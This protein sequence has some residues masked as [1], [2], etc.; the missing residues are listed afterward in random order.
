MLHTGLVETSDQAARATAY[1]N[2]VRGALAN[3]AIVGTHWFQFC[4]QAVTGRGDG[5]NYQIG[6]LDVCDT[7]YAETIEACREIGAEMY[8]HRWK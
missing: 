3:P 1:R 2:Y 6:L 8:R 4:D 7:P 5:E